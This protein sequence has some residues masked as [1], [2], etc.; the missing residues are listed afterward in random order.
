[1]SRIETLAEF[2]TAAERLDPEGWAASR[3]A[4]AELE[5]LR[6]DAERY[7]TLRASLDG[8]GERVRFSMYLPRVVVPFEDGQTYTRDGLDEA[9]DAAMK[10]SK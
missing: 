6:R 8:P 7:R 10:D 1:M 2:W 4:Q 9:I 5:S 3:K